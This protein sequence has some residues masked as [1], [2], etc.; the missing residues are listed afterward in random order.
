MAKPKARR[1][2]S[3][4]VRKV[5]VTSGEIGA[6]PDERLDVAV[7]ARR[8]TIEAP[9]VI[10]TAKK[11]A[12]RVPSGSTVLR[13]HAAAIA[14]NQLV[15]AAAWK[16]VSRGDADAVRPF[17]LAVDRA[18]SAIYGRLVGWELIGDPAATRARR[19]T[20][21]LFPTG[22]SFTQLPWSAQWA[23][24]EKRLAQIADEK[25]GPM[26]RE[27]VG[28][29]FVSALEAR[30]RE[31]G[32]ALGMHGMHHREA[33]EAQAVMP[34][35][36]ATLQSMADYAVQVAAAHNAERD[37]R[38]RAAYRKALAPIDA[39]RHAAALRDGID[40]EEPAPLAVSPD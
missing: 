39:A 23:E 26:L 21:L 24:G 13:A 17:D 31:Y 4:T 32:D 36:R 33:A 40:G 16:R 10:A 1:A 38:R 5:R 20:A 18:W 34:I 14:S 27:L 15:L 19:L 8:L 28:A 9:E 7:Y 35:L 29:E 30:Q 37:P 6:P 25:L 12:S 3:K 22:L 2:K 11:I